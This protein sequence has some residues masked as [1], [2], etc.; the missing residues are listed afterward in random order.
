MREWAKQ[1][2][3]EKQSTNSFSL[4]LKHT[5][6]LG[7]FATDEQNCI[8]LCIYHVAEPKIEPTKFTKYHTLNIARVGLRPSLLAISQILL[9][10]FS[11][12]M[13][14]SVEGVR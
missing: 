1:N 5:H 10:F 8:L 11:L 7:S 13:G 3:K 9:I 14:W 4:V 12:F 6:F 2:G